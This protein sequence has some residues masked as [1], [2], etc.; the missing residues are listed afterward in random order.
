[1]GGV[2]LCSIMAGESRKSIKMVLLK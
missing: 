2:Y 1:A